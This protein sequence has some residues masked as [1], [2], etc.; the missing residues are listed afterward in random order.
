MISSYRLGDLV[1]LS[2][3]Q[4]DINEISRDFPNSI[5]ASYINQLAQNPSLNKIDLITTI[6]LKELEEKCHLLPNDIKS[7]TVI[8][9]RLGDVV[10]GNQSHE[11]IKRPFSINELKE[12]VPNNDKIYVIGKPFFAKPSS[13]NYQECIDKSNEYLN[14]VLLNFDGTYLDLG[15]ADLDLLA[16]V[17]SKTFIKGKG[18]FSQ[19]INDIRNNS[20]KFKI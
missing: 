9:L 8:H 1:L 2:L 16:G 20:Y 3:N 17:A 18:F 12:I 11:I 5:G 4:A 15:N 10:T 19:L 13:N 14:E 6:V 7:S